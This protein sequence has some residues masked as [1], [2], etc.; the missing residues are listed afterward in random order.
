MDCLTGIFPRNAATKAR[1]LVFSANCIIWRVRNDVVHRKV[2][3]FLPQNQNH[4]LLFAQT[5]NVSM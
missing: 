2:G 4:V 5:N 1:S 3:G